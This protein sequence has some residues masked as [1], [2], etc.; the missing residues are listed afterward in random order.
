MCA[1]VAMAEAPPSAPPKAPL[2][3]KARA[4]ALGNELMMRYSSK[5]FQKKLGKLIASSGGKDGQAILYVPGRHEL[6]L[7][8]QS[9][10]LPRFGFDASA[11]GVHQMNAA[12]EPLLDDSQIMK[13]LEGIHKHLQL[14][15]PK[16][17]KVEKVPEK[18]MEKQDAIELQA[19]LLQVYSSADF[20]MKLSQIYKEFG[21]TKLE[22]AKVRTELIRSAQAEVLPKY[23]FEATT[24]GVKKML[25][26]I[27]PLLADHDVYSSAVLIDEVL[28]SPERNGMDTLS[29]GNVIAFMRESLAAFGTPDFQKS[30]ADRR[31][32]VVSKVSESILRRYGMKGGRAGTIMMAL[33]VSEYISSPEVAKIVD[34]VNATLGMSRSA[35]EHFRGRLKGLRQM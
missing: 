8:E 25:K 29:R 14:P 26:K 9:D 10:V 17:G 11:E 7:R 35:C 13:L 6:V 27:E 2:L 16:R 12:L 21:Q 3:T 1:A 15:A 22:H 32:K 24:D 23:G 34:A 30:S 4:S 33:N 31:S 20:Q 28:Y 5:S 19:D 18:Q